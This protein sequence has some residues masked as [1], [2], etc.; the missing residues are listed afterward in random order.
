MEIFAQRFVKFCWKLW[1]Y[2]ANENKLSDFILLSPTFI[3]SLM[4]FCLLMLEN[5]VIFLKIIY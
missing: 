4:L 1:L 3:P 5:N 2:E